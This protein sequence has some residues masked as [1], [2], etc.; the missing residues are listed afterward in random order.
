MPV[1][2]QVQL[3]RD[4]L[5]SVTSAEGSLMGL[6]PGEPRGSPAALF[7]PG[8]SPRCA[9]LPH[10]QQVHVPAGA[11]TELPFH[12]HGWG[13]PPWLAVG[14][15]SLSQLHPRCSCARSR[16]RFGP[17]NTAQF[18]A[19]HPAGELSSPTAAPP[20]H[21]AVLCWLGS[22]EGHKPTVTLNKTLE[23]KKKQGKAL[24][25]R[26]HARTAEL[27]IMLRYLS[28]NA[29]TP[30]FSHALVTRKFPLPFYQA[31]GCSNRT[32]ASQLP[33]GTA[34]AGPGTHG[35][36]LLVSHRFSFPDFHANAA[37]LSTREHGELQ[38]SQAEPIWCS[39]ILPPKQSQMETRPGREP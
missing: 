8:K 13:F 18:G 30:R 9:L 26:Q 31:L 21:V 29:L 12:P 2:A 17:Q 7:H 1:P 14:S 11:L 5:Q 36:V 34:A 16:T 23:K 10:H 4:D 37:W 24:V 3:Q 28:V 6:Q 22:H 38:A 33:M 39:S 35:Q 19:Q 32:A 20:A 25:G 27:Q 15:R